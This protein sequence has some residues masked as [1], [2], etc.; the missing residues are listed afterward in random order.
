MR[1]LLAQTERKATPL[2]SAAW[3]PLIGEVHLVKPG[4]CFPVRC[5]CCLRW[6]SRFCLKGIL[7]QNSCKGEKKRTPS[8]LLMC[9]SE[10]EVVEKKEEQGG[11]TGV[12]GKGHAGCLVTSLKTRHTLPG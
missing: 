8:A 11:V 12:A 6:T 3:F 9:L 10:E 2:K 1:D 5:N 4:I 7:H